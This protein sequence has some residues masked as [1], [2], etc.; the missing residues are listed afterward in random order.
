MDYAAVGAGMAGVGGVMQAFGNKKAQNKARKARLR[1]LSQGMKDFQLG[2]T[3]ASGNRYNF[4]QQRGWGYDL[5]NAGRA[6]KNAANRG[7]YQMAALGNISPS[8]ARNNLVAADYKAARNQAL[9]NQSAATRNALR[10]GSNVG[11]V[12]RAYG[13]VGSQALQ[14]SMQQQLRNGLQAHI[15]NANNYAA[16]AQ[17]LATPL[18]NIQANLQNMQNGAATQQMQ[19]RQAMAEAAGVPK[20]NFLQTLG[21]IGQGLGMAMGQYKQ[22]NQANKIEALKAILAGNEGNID[23]VT[24]E[25]IAQF[26]KLIGG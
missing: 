16:L 22:G 10:T 6:A 21:G 3:D 17:N 12:I 4:N 2:S 23:K 13:S 14:N 20:Q 9:A 1:Q 26:L 8:Q 5:S 11:D 15:Q 24:P 18:N 7:M 19:L 25:Q